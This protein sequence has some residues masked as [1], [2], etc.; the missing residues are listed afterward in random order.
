MN[1]IR[2]S[3]TKEFTYAPLTPKRQSLRPTVHSMIASTGRII[4]IL[5]DASTVIKWQARSCASIN[6]ALVMIVLGLGIGIDTKARSRQ[7][8]FVPHP[9]WLQGRLLSCIYGLCV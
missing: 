4:F 9:V 2:C 5:K 1:K 8:F 7:F 6:I 3:V